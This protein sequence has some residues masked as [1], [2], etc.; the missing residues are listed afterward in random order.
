MKQNYAA[1]ESRK[2]LDMLSLLYRLYFTSLTNFMILYFKTVRIG[3]VML[4]VRA[5]QIARRKVYKTNKKV[6]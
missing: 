3:R 6:P 1:C 5:E 4:Y 2:H